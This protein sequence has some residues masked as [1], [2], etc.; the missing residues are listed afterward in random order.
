MEFEQILKLIDAVSASGLSGLEL[1]EN[2]MRLRLAA[3]NSGAF[4]QAPPMAAAEAAPVKAAEGA[5]E[6]SEASEPQTLSQLSYSS[7]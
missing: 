2:G 7:S 4:F 5:P 6:A 1:E 3:G